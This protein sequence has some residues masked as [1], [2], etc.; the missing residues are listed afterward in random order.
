MAITGSDLIEWK[1]VPT[2][3]SFSGYDMDR[4]IGNIDVVSQKKNIV[5]GKPFEQPQHTSYVLQNE[6]SWRDSNGISGMMILNFLGEWFEYKNG[7][8]FVAPVTEEPV[9]DEP[10]VEEPIDEEMPVEETQVEP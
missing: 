5:D 10:S 7:V 4:G 9:A 2:T 1:K 3:I 6:L 8:N